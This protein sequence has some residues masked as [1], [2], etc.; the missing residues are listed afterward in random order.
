MEFFV[1]AELLDAPEYSR[2]SWHAAIRNFIWSHSKEFAIR[3]EGST[4]LL[5]QLIFVIYRYL[6]QMITGIVVYR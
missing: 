6:G 1:V 3:Q 4:L 5:D 2:E